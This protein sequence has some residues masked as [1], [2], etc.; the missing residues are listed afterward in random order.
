M[1]VE[2]SGCTVGVGRTGCWG[3][4]WVLLLRRRRQGLERRLER[5]EE[6]VVEGGGG[7]RVGFRMDGVGNRPEQEEA[8]A[9]VGI[10]AAVDD[11]EPGPELEEVVVVADG[12]QPEEGRLDAVVGVGGGEGRELE[13]EEV[14]SRSMAQATSLIRTRHLTTPLVEEVAVE[15]GPEK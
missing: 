15:V 13:V 2:V 5:G 1:W 6:V 10:V 14:L 9:D 3:W 8:E 4:D 11:G 12:R 7:G